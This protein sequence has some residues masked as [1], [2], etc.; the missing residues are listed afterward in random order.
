MNPDS[1]PG[2]PTARL[3]AREGGRA[4]PLA[5]PLQRALEGAVFPLGREQLVRIARENSAAPALLTLLSALPERGAFASLDAVATAVEAASS[6]P[7]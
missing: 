1:S 7:R 4:R 6:Q 3:P 5:E 2:S